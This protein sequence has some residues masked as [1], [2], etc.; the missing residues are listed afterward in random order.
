MKALVCGEG[1]VKPELHIFQMFLG[2]QIASSPQVGWPSRWMC[3]GAFPSPAAGGMLGQLAGLAG[4]VG[5]SGKV[6]RCLVFPVQAVKSIP[7]WG[8]R[9]S[10]HLHNPQTCILHKLC[11]PQEHEHEGP[12]PPAIPMELQKPRDV[13]RVRENLEEYSGKG[14][15]GGC[16]EDGR[17]G[18]G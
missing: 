4:E 6:D 18:W 12:A 5:S 13:P 7:L 11:F 14:N 10:M 15:P 16:G 1:R 9:W 2:L 8:S 3:L 17:R